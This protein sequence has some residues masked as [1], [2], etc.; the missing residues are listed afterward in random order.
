MDILKNIG[1]SPEQI[2]IYETLLEYGKLPAS[3]IASRSKVSR[4]ITYKILD[5]LVIIGI[6]EKIEAPKS[7]ALFGPTDPENLRKL[8]EH[9]QNEVMSLKNACETAIQAIRPKYNL[10]TNKPGVLFYEG[11]EGIKKVLDDSL[12]TTDVIYQYIDLDSVLEHFGEL[13][14]EYVAKRTK[15]GISK[16]VLVANSVIAQDY[17]KKHQ[18]SLIDMKIINHTQTPFGVSML[19]YDDKISYITIGKNNSELIGIIIEDT[20]LATMHKY[21]FEALYTTSKNTHD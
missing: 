20:R 14:T 17:F 3:I 19:I 11:L 13:N 7:V 15:A 18:E 1:F 6:V 12:Y 8:V 9:K 10:L 4:V 2:A 16:K 5:Q 21:L